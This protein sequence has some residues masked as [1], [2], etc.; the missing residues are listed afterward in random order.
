V[1]RAP[2]PTSRCYPLW[3][4]ISYHVGRHYPSFIAHTGSWARPA[5]H[6]ERSG[7]AGG[8]K[9]STR[10]RLSL[11]RLVFA[12]CCQS[13][14]GDG[15]SQRYLC[16]PCMGA[17]TLTPRCSFGALT[18]SFPK[19][20]G[21]TLDLRRSA[22]QTT[23]AMQLQQGKLFRGCSHSVMFRLPCSL[24]PQVAPTAKAQR[25]QGSQAVYTTQWTCGYP[26]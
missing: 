25:L 5:R 2:L 21:L 12:G 16:N 13:L 24:D 22:H 3:R 9:P 10:L 23:P 6:R 14:L 7:E 26:T 4:D 19:N 8:P 20:I 1:P 17:W 11:L 18:R 15:P